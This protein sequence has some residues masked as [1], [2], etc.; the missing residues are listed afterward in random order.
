MR[1]STQTLVALLASPLLAFAA[2]E[3]KFTNSDYNGITAGQTFNIKWDPTTSG[4]VSLILR[5]GA[6][7]NLTPGVYVAQGISNSGSYS[8]SVP[9]DITR[10]SDYALE[11]VDDSNT[12]NVNYT[13]Q[14]VVDS[15]NT[16]ASSTSYISQSASASASSAS[17]SASSSASSA[18]RSASSSAAS[19]S[20]SASSASGSAS[21]SL[22]SASR[23]AS[24]SAAS[25]SSSAA[26]RASSASNSVAPTSTGGAM[27]S[28]IPFGLMALGA[29]AL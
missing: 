27:A 6:S 21:S 18:S 25:A 9:S 29:L 10:G 13:P 28:A 19:A 7:N 17:G 20:S 22:S 23:S 11:I 15:T 24:S 4:T 16:V 5:S 12:S 14:F 8:W 2:S 3:N 26:S 1:F